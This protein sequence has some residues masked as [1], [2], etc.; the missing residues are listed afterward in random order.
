MLVVAGLLGV[1][2]IGEQQR[3]AVGLSS[4]ASAPFGVARRPSPRQP[5][6]EAPGLSCEDPDHADGPPAP[7]LEHVHD[8]RLQR[9]PEYPAPIV[10]AIFFSGPI[11][12]GD[13]LSR[14][15]PTGFAYG[16]FS[17]YQLK[18]IQARCCGVC[19]LLP[20]RVVP[21][22]LRALDCIFMAAPF[23]FWGRV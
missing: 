20:G 6:R 19:L 11:A 14:S 16:E 5:R 7:H 3:R 1:V 12:L 17:A 21:L 8:L 18:I 4:T 15:P 13:M 22:E 2:L 9:P 10:A 23:A